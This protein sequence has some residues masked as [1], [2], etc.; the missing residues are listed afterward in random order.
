[1]DDTI[2]KL[3]RKFRTNDPFQISEGM[4]ILIRFTS[5][6]DGTRG[7]YYRT[8]RRRFI[9]IDENLDDHWQRFVCAHELAHDRLHPGFNRFW[10]DEHSFFNVGKFECQANRFALKL[11]THTTDPEIGESKETY[12]LRCSIPR[13]L[14]K[15]Y[16]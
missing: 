11:L 9:V 3:V 8:L 5:F 13:E 15:F 14:H 16:L 2:T 7:L 6:G 10:L 1:M 12:L 4:N